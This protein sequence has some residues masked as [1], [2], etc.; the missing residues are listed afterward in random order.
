MS[1]KALLIV[2][3][4]RSKPGI[5]QDIK[6]SKFP[7]K[8]YDKII[9][10]KTEEIFDTTVPWYIRWIPFVNNWYDQFIS[11]I[12]AL[13]RNKTARMAVCREVRSQI[14]ILQAEGYEVDVL[15]YSLGTLI[16]LTCASQANSEK[17]QVNHLSLYN[18]PLGFAVPFLGGKCRKFV[19]KYGKNFLANKIECVYGEKDLV[20]KNCKKKAS[21]LLAHFSLDKI[22]FFVTKE[23]HDLITNINARYK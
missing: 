1:K 22:K 15:A 11:D 21:G 5:R 20:S 7:T 2:D 13:F 19:R 10:A 14:R 12:W 16:A 3:G 9:R 4:I 8:G 6:N 23:K 17:T 18:S